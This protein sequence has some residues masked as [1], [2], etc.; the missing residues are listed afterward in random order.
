MRKILILF[1]ALSTFVLGA[2]STTRY[3]GDIN[4]D[5]DVTIADAAELIKIL[6]GGTDS[7]NGASDADQ[8][9]AVNISDVTRVAEIILGIKEKVAMAEVDT[10]YITYADGT[11]TYQIPSSWEDSVSIT[12]SGGDV[13]L[14]NSCTTEEYITCLSGTSTEGSFTYNGTYKTTL[15]LNG[16]SLTNSDGA[17]IDIQCGKR[18]AL[19]LAEGTTSTLVDGSGGSQKA[20]LNCQGHLEVSKGGSL[21][22]TGNKKHA[23]RSNEYMLLKKTM[24][25]ITV[26]GSTNDGIHC[27]QYFQMNGGTV[28]VSGVT[29]DAIQAEM[30]YDNT[31]DDGKIIIKG[32]T[33]DLQVDNTSTAALKCDSTLHITDGTIT[34]TTTG[35][36]DKGMKS[37][38]DIDIEGGT[39]SITQSGT[40]TVETDTTSSTGYDASHV[41]AIKADGSVII[42]GGDIIITNTADGGKGISSDVS[43]D[44]SGGTQT[45]Y[46]NG[47][48]GVLDT[49]RATT[50]T[51]GE[52]G[53][54]TV[55]YLSG[56]GSQVS[57]ITSGNYYVIAGYAQNGTT[58]N[59]LYDTGSAVAGASLSTGSTSANKYVWQITSSGSGYVLQNLSTGRYINMGTSNG[60]SV[61]TSTTAEE[62]GIVFDSSNYG[63][64]YNTS[65]LY[66]IDVQTQGTSICSWSDSDA[67]PDGSRRLMIYDANLTTADVSTTYSYKVYLTLPSS[68]GSSN[69]FG[70]N[71]SSISWSDIN[72]Y[73]SDGTLVASLSDQ[74][75][76]SGS[77]GSTATFFYYD[78]GA[79]TSGSYYFTANYSITSSGGGGPQG[80]SSSTTTGTYTSDA[81]TL[82]LSG[83][84][85][86]YSVSASSSG[87]GPNSSTSYSFSISDVTSTYSGGS[88]AT[89][90]GDTYSAHAVKSNGT[91]NLTGGTLTM[92]HSGT[93]SKGIKA[94]GAVTLNGATVTDTPDGSYMIVGTDPSYCTSVKCGSFVGESGSLTV[95]AT[96]A[97]SRG[98]SSDGT[99]T[100]NEGTYAFTMT[101]DGS[102]YTADGTSDGVASVGMKSDGNMQLLGGDITINS[103]AKGGKG[104]KGG[105]SEATGASGAQLTIGNQGASNDALNLTVITTGTYLAT[106][107]SSSGEMGGMGGDS[108]FIGSTKAVKVMGPIVVN[109]GNIYLST[110]SDG[111]EGLE[112]KYTIT[113]NGSVFESY[114]YDDAINAADKITVND[115]YI[116]AH[117][118]G[119]D[120]ID[121]NG[122]GF[123]F[124]GGVTVASGATSP[125]E[126]FDC[127][128]Y[129]FVINGGVLIGT[130]GSV[131]TVTSASVPYG[132]ASVSIT[133]GTYLSLQSNGTV[134]ANYL[135]PTDYSN[136]SSSGM[137]GNGGYTVFVAHPSLSSGSA[138]LVYGATAVSGTE[139]SVWDGVYTTGGSVTGGTST[140]I[141]V[142]TK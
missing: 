14:T 113:F 88:T 133:G 18:I 37:D 99:V 61:P 105:T 13:T 53:S 36:A 34:L 70:G 78:F 80:G 94:D 87:G 72:L 35:D 139:T 64:I 142:S 114:T 79:A 23:I 121:S 30:E 8:S 32:G 93:I 9:G 19:E 28:T 115:G 119:N 10:I 11:A 137:G 129:S 102:T 27:G 86:Y 109:S 21:N 47:T 41:T 136:S 55:T 90:E 85:V 65:T 104:I 98:I 39:I 43:V 131:S 38:G 126:S 52:S 127:D 56:Q 71:S 140:S 33:L 77:D 76:I 120:A 125:E 7:S 135:I 3:Y 75:S 5:G 83:S 84:D 67:T 134:L 22:V 59:F 132:S 63:M 91:V 46:A 66:A 141:S 48:G 17:A 24:G 62:L 128:S 95:Y 44:I 6:M 117:A 50:S 138:T 25:S 20:A 118:T 92:Y 49:S 31:E 54:T 2:F 89:E 103:S 68:A 12:V 101:G 111:G 110:T 15:V 97:A 122:N 26:S 130:A 58:T 108:G 40:Y 81:L 42:S 60:A 100:I 45:I 82:N 107:S 4:S 116:W 96:G 123:E 16:V 57:S 1:V 74:V 69:Q 124:N 106:E 51:S 29:G 112:S 73:T